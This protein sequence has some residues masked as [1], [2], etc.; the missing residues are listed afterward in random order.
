MT[1]THLREPTL[2]RFAL[3][4]GESDRSTN[5][6]LESC[7]GCGGLVLALRFLTQ[8]P[9]GSTCPDAADLT[10]FISAPETAEAPLQEHLTA[11]VDCAA[12]SVAG[13]PKRHDSNPTTNLAPIAFRCFIGC[14]SDS[15]RPD[16]SSPDHHRTI[17]LRRSAA[18]PESP[19]FTKNED[20]A[21][22][23]C[24]TTIKLGVP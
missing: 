12:D 16:S 24:A 14:S 19:G 3:T 18:G 10:R 4:P 23:G 7:R 5:T 1:A 21:L 22:R 2:R 15:A 17:A 9:S 20:I 13:A 8:S 6:H 11:C